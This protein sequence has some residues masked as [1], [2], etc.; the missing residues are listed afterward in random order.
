[1]FSLERRLKRHIWSQ[2]HY[3][4]AIASPGL[5]HV[6]RIE[7]RRRGGQEIEIHPG[8]LVF[9]GP[10]ETLYKANLQLRTVDRLYL[11]IDR[12]LAHQAKKIV[13]KCERIPWELYLFPDQERDIRINL[14]NSSYP[15]K[16][17]F[18]RIIGDAINRHF[19]TLP[20]EYYNEISTQKNSDPQTINISIE[21]K[22][23]EIGIDSSGEPLYK[24]GYR[25]EGGRAP[26][27]ETLAA[28]IIRHLGWKPSQPFVDAM[29]GS[30]T[31]A[32]E[33][34]LIALK[35]APGVERSFS[36]MKWPS[37]RDSRF[38]YISKQCRITTTKKTPSIIVGADT[39]KKQLQRAFS[40]AQKA[41]VDHIISFDQ[42]DFLEVLPKHFSSKPG[43]LIM[44]LPYGK[45]ISKT[46]L[47]PFYYHIG[48]R[49]KR[50]YGGW[51]IALIYPATNLEKVFGIPKAKYYTLTSGGTKIRLLSAIIEK[52]EKKY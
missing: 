8:R 39:D 26:I 43:F 47:R 45:R 16:P 48:D 32:I 10:F 51:K 3:F 22:H 5:E 50:F 23:V 38:R 42:H 12:F 14:K 24:R 27:R 20:A 33:A 44:N 29:T 30:G 9:K 18:D 37:F 1:M 46:Q 40:N 7:I 2:Q 4:S 19:E 35:K 41:G 34:A 21:D 13:M 25:K 6:C 11:V 17:G 31:F 52:A 15:V 28:G 36:F 49:L